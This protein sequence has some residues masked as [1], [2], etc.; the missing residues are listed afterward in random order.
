[1]VGLVVQAVV[2]IGTNVLYALT[3]G[4]ESSS[5]TERFYCCMVAVFL[6]LLF[7]CYETHILTKT[8]RIR[9]HLRHQVWRYFAEIILFIQFTHVFLV[10]IV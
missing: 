3:V 10:G 1:M 8:T 5:T 7:C 2:V 6:L 9:T 4:G